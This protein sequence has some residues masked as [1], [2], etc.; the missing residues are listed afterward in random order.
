MDILPNQLEQLDYQLQDS[1]SHQELVP[2]I[3]TYMKKNTRFSIIYT[4]LNVFFFGIIL[5]W[6]WRNYGT[7]GFEI[8]EG[9]SYLSY[10]FAFAFMLVPLHEYIHVL[11]YKSQ[12]AKQ[13]SYDA[14]WKKFYFMA[15]ADKFVANK[16]E[17]QIIAL[18]P[19][20]VISLVFLLF[21][22]FTSKLWTFTI[23]GTLMVHTAFCSGDFG[24][25]SYFDFHKNKEIVT[26]DDVENK[27]SYFYQKE[28]YKQ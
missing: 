27:I 2:F 4:L 12:G 10:G 5:F 16:K 24:L 23:L 22:L 20:V 26:F 8:S 7:E 17:F 14:N 9:I 1:L 25:L 11:A 21:I 13:T 28:N 19:I 3:R 15:L 18:A 6:F